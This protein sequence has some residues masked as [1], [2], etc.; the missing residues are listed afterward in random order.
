MGTELLGPLALKALNVISHPVMLLDTDGR[1]L[2][3]NDA[4][5][6]YV[7]LVTKRN[8][9]QEQ[10][11]GIDVAELHPPAAREAMRARLA[12]V[13]ASLDVM[14]PRTNMVGDLLFVTYDRCL[15][16]E[17]GEAL[18]VMME[19]LPVCIQA[20]GGTSPLA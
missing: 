16:D 8:W 6:G 13:L 2:Y 7:H 1:V 5:L 3:V 11:L 4:M 10:V 14:P 19:K 17:H 15:R 12:S 9:I 18:A 20:P